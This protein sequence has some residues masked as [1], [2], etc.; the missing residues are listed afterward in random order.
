MK[1]LFLVIPLVIYSIT[2]LK[3]KKN[4]QDHFLIFYY[5]YKLQQKYAHD[6]ITPD[7]IRDRFL[8]RAR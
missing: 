8:S 6:D 2:N 5:S 7:V 1:C 4:P 3:G